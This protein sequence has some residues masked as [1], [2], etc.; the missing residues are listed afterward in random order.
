[1]PNK[2]FLTGGVVGNG[3]A[4]VYETGF[5]AVDN[6]SS[7]ERTFY[8]SANGDYVGRHQSGNNFG[9]TTASTKS[10]IICATDESIK[11]CIKY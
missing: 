3:K 6:I 10:G 2:S 7:N 5:P 11:Y 4:T 1:M 9:L 8:P